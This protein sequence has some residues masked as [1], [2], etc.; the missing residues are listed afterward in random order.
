SAT[1][2]SRSIVRLTIDQHVPTDAV[3]GMVQWSRPFGFKNVASG[4]AD[5]RWVDGDSNEDSFNAPAGVPIV[6]PT[7]PTVLALQRSSGGTQ[8]VLGGFV[9]AVVPGVDKP[10]VRASARVDGGGKHHSPRLAPN[11]R[12]A[13]AAAGCRL[14]LAEREDTVVSPRIA[15]L[16]HV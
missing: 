12:A 8:R 14:T 3:G 9:D 10:V 11:L 13:R 5:W 15:A 1:V 2:V 16:Y 7:A 4:G 6:P